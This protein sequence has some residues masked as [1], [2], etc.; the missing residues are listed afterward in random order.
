MSTACLLAVQNEEDSDSET[1]S[2]SDYDSGGPSEAETLVLS[3]SS[4]YDHAGNGTPCRYYNHNGC[5]RGSQCKFKHA[6]DNR[7][8]RDNL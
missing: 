1:D 6:P 2:H 4:D 3:D 8:I 7:S 5:A